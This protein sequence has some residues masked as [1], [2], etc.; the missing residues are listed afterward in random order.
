MAAKLGVFTKPVFEVAGNIKNADMA[1]LAKIMHA[2]HDKVGTGIV[3]CQMR[4]PRD[5]LQN[6]VTGCLKTEH[7]DRTF[8][9]FI[10]GFISKCLTE[11]PMERLD[12]ELVVLG[13]HVLQ[14]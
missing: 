13:E 1:K 9:Q 4:W 11:T 8:H 12:R 2:G 6:S 5:I 7:K 14:L 10:N 3:L